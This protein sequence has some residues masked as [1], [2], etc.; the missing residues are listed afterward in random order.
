MVV[1]LVG[2]ETYRIPDPD[3][4]GKKSHP[5]TIRNTL[6]APIC[7]Y[8]LGLTKRSDCLWLLY[9]GSVFICGLVQSQT[10]VESSLALLFT[11]SISHRVF[12]TLYPDSSDTDG[13]MLESA[14][15]AISISGN[16]PPALSVSSISSIGEDLNYRGADFSNFY[17]TSGAPSSPL[18]SA[19]VRSHF[20]NS[21]GSALNSPSATSI[22]YEGSTTPNY[23]SE[24]SK[25]SGSH[26][27][28]YS[29]LDTALYAGNGHSSLPTFQEHIEDFDQSSFPSDAWPGVRHD[30]RSQSFQDFDSFSKPRR[31]TPD[32]LE[33]SNGPVFGN[34]P[35]SNTRSAH[36]LNNMGSLD[37]NEQYLGNRARSAS[38]TATLGY[39]RGSSFSH[40]PTYH[41]ELTF[42]QSRLGG[43]SHT[44][45]NGI[46][47]QL[48]ARNREESFHNPRQRVMSADAVHN[49]ASGRSLFESSQSMMTPHTFS[50]LSSNPYTEQH[51][52][53]PRSFSSGTTTCPP[54][55]SYRNAPHTTN[56]F[57]DS[58][59]STNHSQPSMQG[60]MAD[61]S[62]LFHSAQ[63]G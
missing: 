29:S 11:H 59:G 28:K 51:H 55:P 61:G 10:K 6:E 40:T 45:D 17:A 22:R 58:S 18:S 47:P 57:I 34:W 23:Q 42:D 5:T 25:G 39:N 27:S 4:V 62:A 49:K 24:T 15:S 56:Y 30:D 13:K 37:E 9:A 35:P 43:Y 32:S 41:E 36:S 1:Q 52:N 14:F 12:L 50:P 63:V 38:A 26:I 3:I 53:R 46:I 16:R 44:S 21:S 2:K 33:S 20:H 8:A 19:S 7:I 48:P 31:L 60:R 54:T